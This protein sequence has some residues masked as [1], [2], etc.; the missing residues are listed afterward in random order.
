MDSGRR[1]LFRLSR[2]S[3]TASIPTVERAA[4]RNGIA[5]FWKLLAQFAANPQAPQRWSSLPEDHPIIHWNSTAAKLEL[6]PRLL[7]P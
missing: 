3:S 7:Q 2:N 5:A 1:S 4:I 6:S